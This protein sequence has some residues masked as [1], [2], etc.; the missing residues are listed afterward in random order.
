LTRGDWLSTENAG[1]QRRKF[2]TRSPLR[3]LVRVWSSKCAPSGVHCIDCFLAKRLLSSEL[4][5]DSTKGCGDH[6]AGAPSSGVVRNQAAVPPQIVQEAVYHPRQS[7]KFRVTAG[8]VPHAAFDQPQP[9]VGTFDF[10]MPEV[11][12][13]VLQRILQVGGPLGIQMS[14]PLQALPDAGDPH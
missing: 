14:Q 9:V 3:V 10:A 2:W 13:G 7:R 11:P 5:S 4:T 6:L 8:E 12:S 1:Y